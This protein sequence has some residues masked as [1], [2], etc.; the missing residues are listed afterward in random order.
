MAKT[1]SNKSSAA[2]SPNQIFP[3]SISNHRLSAEEMHDVV[4]EYMN[5]LQALVFITLSSNDASIWPP[6]AREANES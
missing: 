4:R 2:E 3:P 1:A 6:M 5:G